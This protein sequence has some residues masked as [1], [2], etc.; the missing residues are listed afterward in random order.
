M[1]D[2]SVSTFWTDL[3]HL[4]GFAVVHVREDEVCQRYVITVVPEHPVGV[5]P[6]CHRVTEMVKQRRTREGILDWPIGS[7]AVELTVRVGQFECPHCDRCFTLTIEF[8]A[9]GAHGTERLLGRVAELIRHSDVS[10][11]A[12]FFGVAEK[13]LEG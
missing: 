6:H 8:L 9:E 5:C 4:P 11:A 12:R 3:L 1:P 10:N 2:E 13:T 7:H